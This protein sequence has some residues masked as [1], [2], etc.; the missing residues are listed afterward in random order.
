MGVLNVTP[1]SFFDGGRF[2]DADVAIARGREMFAEGAD[3]V[4]VGG[5]SSRPGAEPV[6]LEEE[7]RRVLPVVRALAPH[8][9]ISIDTMKPEVAAQACAAGATLVNDVAG[10]CI[11]VAARAGAGVVVM[12]MQGEPATMQRGPRYGDVVAEV[13]AALDDGAVRAR[14][15]GISEV[16]VDP[17]IGFGKTV[18]HNLA[19][20]AALPDLVARGTPVLVGTSRKSFLG[21][22]IADP[23]GKARPTDERFEGSLAT[24]VWAMACGCA[25]VRAHD[26][27][28]TAQAA[29]LVGEAAVAS[30][31]A[32]R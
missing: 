1:D 27:N 28:E 9:R 30:S 32:A 26:V 22:V 5:E 15:A 20:L 10:R 11:D 4:D 8:G 3:I 25:I 24:A 16:Y 13:F 6:C 18:E 19:L 7:L 29:R 12:H 14:G 23:G 2:L 21:K 31:G 17:G